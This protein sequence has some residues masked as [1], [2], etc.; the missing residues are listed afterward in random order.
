MNQDTLR[1]AL[2]LPE[3]API[4]GA[5]YRRKLANKQL[6]FATVIA[7]ELLGNDRWVA[8]FASVRFGE[9]RITSEHNNL[10]SYELHS[11]PQAASAVIPVISNGSNDVLDALL[12]AEA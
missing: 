10:R 3:D 2:E 6:E 1:K 9:E 11:I 5:M 12:S 4:P 8:V 7:L